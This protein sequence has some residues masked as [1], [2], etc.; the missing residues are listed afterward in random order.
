MEAHREL[1]IPLAAVL[2]V[3]VIALGALQAFDDT[4]AFWAFALGVA[5]LAVQGARFARLE[6]L[7]LA[8]KVASVAINLALV[9]MLVA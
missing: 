2:P 9:L 6:R 5:T 4:R 7:S 1:A 8:G 3:A